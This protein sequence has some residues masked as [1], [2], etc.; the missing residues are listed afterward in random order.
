MHYLSWSEGLR[1]DGVQLSSRLQTIIRFQIAA[2]L[3]GF[4]DQVFDIDMQI[5]FI[6]ILIVALEISVRKLNLTSLALLRA[7]VVIQSGQ[8]MLT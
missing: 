2:D 5:S 6:I 4:L 7:V 3:Q 1:H 8:I